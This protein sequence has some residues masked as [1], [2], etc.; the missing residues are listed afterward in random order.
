MVKW[1]RA[2]AVPSTP[3]VWWLHA[4]LE[5]PIS[6]VPMHTTP[7]LLDWTPLDTDKQDNRDLRKGGEMKKYSFMLRLKSPAGEITPELYKVCVRACWAKR[8]VD[9]LAGPDCKGRACWAKRRGVECRPS[10]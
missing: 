4:L 5:L 1:W 7:P 9:W 10:L 8:R 2:H 6:H 3:W